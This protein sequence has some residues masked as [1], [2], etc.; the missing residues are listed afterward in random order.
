MLPLGKAFWITWKHNNEYKIVKNFSCLV[1]QVGPDYVEQLEGAKE[2]IENEIGGEHADEHDTFKYR[3][4]ENPCWENSTPEAF[5][6][7][8]NLTYS[9]GTITWLPPKLQRI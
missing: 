6:L 4:V 3:G 2:T 7:S 5:M 1:Q 9:P 8:I